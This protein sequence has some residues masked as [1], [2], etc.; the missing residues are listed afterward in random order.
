MHL[1]SLTAINLRVLRAVDLSIDADLIVF[2]GPNG[3][4]KSSLLE[5][6][7][8]LGTGRSFRARSVQDVIKRDE[9]SLLVRAN[10]SDFAGRENSLAIEKSRK[11]AA[12]FRLGNEAVKSASVLARQLPLVFVSADSQ[13]LLSDG[14]DLRRKQLDWLMFHVE[15]SYQQV[16]GQYRRALAQRNA[17][18]KASHKQSKDECAAWS[19]EMANAGEHLHR[20]REQ[21]L[22]IAQPMLELAFKEL[23]GLDIEF[24]YKAGWSMEEPLHELLDSSWEL[25]KARGFSGIGPHRADLQ[26]KVDGRPAQHV[27]SRGEGKVLVF[28]IFIAFARVLSTSVQVRPLMLVDELASELDSMNRE[29]FLTALRELGMQTFITTVSRSLVNPTG[30]ERVCMYE[31]SQG[32]ARQVLQ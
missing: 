21:R 9:A 10:F 18:L 17:M 4:G 24:V 15:P 32:D 23:S 8:L 1:R 14:A 3:S 30:W 11:G 5:A 26:F 28:A 6:I 19:R 25:D 2:S 22:Q 13:R 7:H 16:F 31:L 27:V 12:R 20:L 29:R